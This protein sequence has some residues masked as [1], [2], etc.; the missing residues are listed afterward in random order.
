MGW[1]RLGLFLLVLTGLSGLLLSNAAMRLPLVVLGV[2]TLSL[3][4]S[5]W[6][7]GAFALGVALAGWVTVLLR[8]AQ[9]GGRSSRGRSGGDAFA[10]GEED[11]VEANFRVPE[12]ERGKGERSATPGR[13]PSS[14]AWQDD[15][16]EWDQWEESGRRAGQSG[17]G[18][19]GS[20]QSGSGQS[21]AVGREAVGREDRVGASQGEPLDDLVKRGEADRQQDRQQDREDDWRGEP[22][23]DRR[24]DLREP[25]SE[26][27]YRPDPV[28]SNP[29]VVYDAD[30]RVIR[31]PSGGQRQSSPAP[32]RWDT[33]SPPR[34]SSPSSSSGSSSSSSQGSS[35]SGR[36]VDSGRSVASDSSFAKDDWFDDDE[37]W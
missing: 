8:V 19:S 23:E 21:V 9:E 25:E 31:P 24:D 18:Q 36:S 20:G 22:L 12:G 17:S 35:S 4:L 11:F 37:D 6:M 14:P 3:P 27:V 28:R 30:Y 7:L 32:A 1:I 26:Y 5:L 16:E 15:R 29:N 34:K 33:E 13:R 10:L 2:P